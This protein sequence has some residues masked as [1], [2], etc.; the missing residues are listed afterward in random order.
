MGSACS[1]IAQIKRAA[2]AAHRGFTLAVLTSLFARFKQN[3]RAE[4]SVNLRGNAE[5]LDAPAKVTSALPLQDAE[6]GAP[7]VKLA[8]GASVLGLG[9]VAGPGA[10]P[11]SFAAIAR[12]HDASRTAPQMVSDV[13]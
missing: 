3:P 6:L 2:N 10:F 9:G 13:Q 5:P 7:K 1:G 4:Q 11:F 8:R 12:W